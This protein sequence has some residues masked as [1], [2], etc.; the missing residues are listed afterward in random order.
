MHR[1][2][3]KKICLTSI[4]A[5]VMAFSV[6]PA[7]GQT[8]EPAETAVMPDQ[9]K[10]VTLPAAPGL[11]FS[12]LTGRTEKSGYYEIRVQLAA[13]AMVPPHTHPDTRCVTV[14]SGELSAG[15]GETA[16]TGQMKS[17][18]AGS[19]HCVPGGTPHYV[20]AMKGTVVFQEGGIGP[21]G[22]T[23]IKK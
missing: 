6:A 21:T 3:F 12:Y 23:F 22:I 16:N 10:W 19:F 1:P 5:P 20:S 13:G 8:A 2:R 7:L 17:F 4:A 15:T 14:L 9:I 11:Q 18:P